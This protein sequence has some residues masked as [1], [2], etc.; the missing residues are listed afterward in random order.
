MRYTYR[1]GG[2]LD[3]AIKLFEREA[4]AGFKASRST[5]SGGGMTQ[6]DVDAYRKANP[7]SKLQTAV[8]SKNPSKSDAKRRGAYCRRSAG[9]MRM[10]NISCSKTPNKRICA[11]RRR[12]RC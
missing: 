4:K 8:T 10:H 9:Q 6:A 3:R 2:H 1:K 12:W 11:T 7:G 5:E